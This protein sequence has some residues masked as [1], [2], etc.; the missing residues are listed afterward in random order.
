MFVPRRRDSAQLLKNDNEITREHVDNLPS[1]I[2]GFWERRYKSI[3]DE[4]TLKLLHTVCLL[5]HP[6]PRE[7]LTLLTGISPS[8]LAA[9]LNDS[10]LWGL[11]DPID[12]DDILS[13]Q[14]WKNCPYPKHASA[15]ALVEKKIEEDEALKNQVLQ[16]IT[17]YYTDA[18]GEDLSEGGTTIH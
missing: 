4:N 7:K 9:A 13:R 6:Y 16:Q 8:A 17:S 2:R 11:L 1:D 18:I 14:L 5:S 3:H 12:F 10:A 15:K